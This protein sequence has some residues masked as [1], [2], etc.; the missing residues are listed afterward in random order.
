M[1]ACDILNFDALDAT[2]LKTDPFEYVALPGFVRADAL[3]VIRNDFPQFNKPG[4]IPLPQLTYGS[5]FKDFIG[6][7]DGPEFERAISHKFSIDLSEKPTMFTLRAHCRATD[8]KIH[9]DSVTKIIT[10]LV[11]L[12]DD[13]WQH[14]GG[15]LRLLRSKN[16]EDYVAEVPPNG[17]TLIVFRRSD[18][19]YHGHESYEGSR[20][21]LQMNWVTSQN[22]VKREQFRHK[23]STWFKS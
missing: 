13:T 8:G 16:L 18:Y 9:V 3:T 5:V 22:V 17:G 4:S 19:S 20:W 1:N 10:V 2:E 11:Y 12:N 6:A 23:I 14:D 7:M 15:R 21:A